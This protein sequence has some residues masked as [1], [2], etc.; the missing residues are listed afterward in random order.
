MIKLKVKKLHPDAKLPEFV[1]HGDAGMDLFSKEKV[2]IKVGERVKISTGIAVEIPHGYVGL[3][4]DK[5][6]LAATHML[7]NLGGVMDAG[8]RGEYIV[9]LINLG[10][11]DYVVEKHHKIGQLLIQKVE[12]PKIV[13]VEE[14]SDSVRGTG[15]FGSSGK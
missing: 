6:G 13:E 1:H 2:T 14:L 12:H 5:S 9:T 4:W 3:V 15:G 7:K 10:H 11:E 8:Y